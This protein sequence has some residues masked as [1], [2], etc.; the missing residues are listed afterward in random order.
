[1][2]A[3]ITVASHDK[4]FIM[5]SAPRSPILQLPPCLL[6]E[7]LDLLHSKEPFQLRDL[8]AFCRTCKIV[9]H[10]GMPWLYRRFQYT[11]EG[12]EF[13]NL[14]R[15]YSTLEHR[16]SLGIHTESLDLAM[17]RRYNFSMDP[18]AYRLPPIVIQDLHRRGVLEDTKAWK[19]CHILA[20]WF[21]L[22]YGLILFKTPML[23]SLSLHYSDEASDMEDNMRS[24]IMREALR[25]PHPHRPLSQLEE[26]NFTQP[27]SARQDSFS[28]SYL[29]FE[30]ISFMAPNLKRLSFNVGAW[31]PKY[32]LP[33]R[34]L[35]FQSLTHLNLGGT[36]I[37]PEALKLILFSCKALVCFYFMPVGCRFADF[38]DVWENDIR[39][40][41]PNDVLG[42]L[43]T[44]QK[45]LENLKLVMVGAKI[46][47]G[48]KSIREKM[49]SMNA[50]ERLTHLTLDTCCYHSTDSLSELLPPNLKSFQLI[51][52]HR[53][54]HE[55]LQGL[56]DSMSRQ[57]LPHL[58]NVTLYPWPCAALSRTDI[59]KL[60]RITDSFRRK[61][62]V[63][64]SSHIHTQLEFGELNKWIGYQLDQYLTDPLNEDL[65]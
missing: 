5:H 61:G 11:G 62:V 32:E 16:R 64:S 29:F 19:Y 53:T 52:M 46:P 1:M 22:A 36:R 54:M 42:P 39:P 20:A 55:E 59:T 58:R 60:S 2:T 21:D 49:I 56:A 13:G 4:N 12:N 24:N 14:K 30:L 38:D 10:L 44:Q 34:E 31:D 33:R 41:Q 47:H 57:R 26:I 8:S 18:N 35:S 63:F 17:P 45:T 40:A 48:P 9:Y 6:V 27:S 15:F 37:P 28:T 3:E 51:G 50:F 23:K 25:Y 65:D 7:L 43:R